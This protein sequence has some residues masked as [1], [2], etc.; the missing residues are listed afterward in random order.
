VTGPDALAD[1][2]ALTPF[3]GQV[4]A[5]LVIVPAIPLQPANV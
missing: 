5:T 4:P 2:V 3:A 1:P